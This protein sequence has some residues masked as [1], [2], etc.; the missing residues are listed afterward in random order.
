ML[1]VAAFAAE[2]AVK[3]IAHKVIVHFRFDV[4]LMGS[5]GSFF[6]NSIY[7]GVATVRGDTN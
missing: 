7:S 6:S 5:R 4:K 1:Y 3:N 2:R